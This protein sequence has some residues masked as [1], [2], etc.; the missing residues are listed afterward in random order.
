MTIAQTIKRLLTWATP[1]EQ[2]A[3]AKIIFGFFSPVMI[4]GP[5][6]AIAAVVNA[7]AESLL[8]PAIEGDGEKAK[9]LWQL[10][11]DPER[12]AFDRVAAIKLH[13]GIDLATFPDAL[14]QCHAVFW[15]MNYSEKRARDAIR[16]ARN[17]ADATRAWC[18]LYERPGAPGQADKRAAKAGA[19]AAQFGV[20]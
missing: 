6:G 14:A 3:N 1:A 17:A 10:H 16:A 13:T 12:P 9:G 20:T 2:Q 8:T 11:V 18:A 4:L 15:E 19:W 7:S 5:Y